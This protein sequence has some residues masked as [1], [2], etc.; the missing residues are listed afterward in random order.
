[1]KKVCIAALIGV[2]LL[3]L[4]ACSK[5]TCGLCNEEKFGKKYENELLGIDI[6]K[7]CH[8]EIEK[9]FGG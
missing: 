5:F 9:A 4:T 8:D 2:M 3:G 1:M 6:C 7:D